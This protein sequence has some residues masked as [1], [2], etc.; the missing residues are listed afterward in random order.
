M[1]KTISIMLIIIVIITSIIMGT[2]I[3]KKQ[4]AKTY[5]GEG[6]NLQ[7]ADTENIIDDCTEEWDGLEENQKGELVQA[8]SQEEK[9]S[10]NCSVLLKKI[11]LKC[12]HI[13]EERIEIPQELVNKTQNDVEQYYSGWEIDKITKDEIVL[14]KEYDTECG[15]HYVFREKDGFIIVYQKTAKGEEVYKETNIPT[16]YLSEADKLKIRD[17]LEVYGEE[18]LNKLIEDFE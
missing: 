8:N 1:N 14:Y 2:I 7:V 15:E 16:D 11:Y 17:G 9:I 13:L 4:F 12:N 18:E 10:P 6:E 3:Y 5:E